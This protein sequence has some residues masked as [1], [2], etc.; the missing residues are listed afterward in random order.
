MGSKDLDL[1]IRQEK[2]W[3]KTQNEKAKPTYN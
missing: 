3:G 2:K 1:I